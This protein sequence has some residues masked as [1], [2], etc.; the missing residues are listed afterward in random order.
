MRTKKY[1]FV[2][3]FHETWGLVKKSVSN[4]FVKNT[5]TKLKIKNCTMLDKKKLSIIKCHYGS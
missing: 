4:F 3:F 5:S 1:C 2:F